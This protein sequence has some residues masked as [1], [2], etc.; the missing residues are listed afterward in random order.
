VVVLVMLMV[1]WVVMFWLWPFIYP[2]WANITHFSKSACDEVK[3]VAIC[4]S[5]SVVRGLI[6]CVSPTDRLMPV[7]DSLKALPLV[8]VRLVRKPFDY[9]RHGIGV[10]NL[11]ANRVNGANAAPPGIV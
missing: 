4:L 10:A 11:G 2:Y 8:L 7:W 3:W 5:A 6:V 1:S 9:E